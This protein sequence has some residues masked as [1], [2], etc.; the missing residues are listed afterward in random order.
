INA[1][2]APG[3]TQLEVRGGNETILL[4]EDDAQLRSLIQA[5][6]EER[7]YT[8]LAAT[9]GDEAL[10]LAHAHPEPIDLLLTDVVM[11]KMS[12]R[13]LAAH[14]TVRQPGLKVLYISGYTDDA[15]V[16]H[17]LLTAEVEFLSKPFSPTI[18]AAKV[19]QVL[20]K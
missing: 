5:T 8:L 2:Q 17:G 6:L 18:L 4:V 14:L 19:R 13:V 12:G 9:H 1:P 20:E 11:P 3:Q 16:R 15:V 10:A 7:G